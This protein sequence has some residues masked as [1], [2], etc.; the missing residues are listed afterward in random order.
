MSPP[1][2]KL[3]H[4]DGT[5][6]IIEP[7]L[8]K[9]NQPIILIEA[10]GL[11]KK[12]EPDITN[13][14]NENRLLVITPFDKSITR[15]TAATAMQRNEFMAELANEIFIAYAAPSGK[16]RNLISKIGRSGKSIST[17]DVEEN[18]ELIESG[19][20]KYNQGRKYGN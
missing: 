9:G 16:L 8:L 6:K 18:K 5:N 19:I 11:K 1:A 7:Y 3:K 13:A 12:Y 17:F 4:G 14:I 20:I 10:R 2:T 15:I